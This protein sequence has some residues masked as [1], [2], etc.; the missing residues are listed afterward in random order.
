MTTDLGAFV[1]A[2]YKR[3]CPFINIPT[4]LLAQVDAAIGFK[5][6]VN[7]DHIKNALGTFAEPRSILSC[8]EFLETLK[9]VDIIYVKVEMLKMALCYNEA[10]INRIN[11]FT[12]DDIK[13]FNDIKIGV[14][15]K[16][17]I[18]PILNAPNKINL[19]ALDIKPN[20]KFKR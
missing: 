16:V 18:V 4:T 20:N 17:K 15:I 1:A 2:T 13:A 9:E 10:L 12:L 8:F 19:L 6:G 14:V 7:H 11:Q 5:C 3:G